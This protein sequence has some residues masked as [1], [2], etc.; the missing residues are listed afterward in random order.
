MIQTQE[1]DQT[2]HFGP[3][4]CPL[5]PNSGPQFFF[6]F[7]KPGVRNCSKLSF[8]AIYRK[9][10]EQNSRKWRIANFRPQFDPFRPNLG[11]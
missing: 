9:T 7:F 3:D 5:G 1:N 2:P 4:L 11:P 10:N 6:F 8:Y